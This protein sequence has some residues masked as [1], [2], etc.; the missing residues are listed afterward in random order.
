[1]IIREN[2]EARLLKERLRSACISKATFDNVIF[3]DEMVE[4]CVPRVL[5]ET[6]MRREYLAYAF[7]AL[8]E[9]SG[10]QAVP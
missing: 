2:E 5:P 10:H 9:D 3:P 7:E 8:S 6:D 1:M 4:I